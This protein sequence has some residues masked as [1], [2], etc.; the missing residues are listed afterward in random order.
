VP[1]CVDEVFGRSLSGGLAVSCFFCGA[2]FWGF[3]RE[4]CLFKFLV[5]WNTNQCVSVSFDGSHGLSPSEANM[6]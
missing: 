2:R 4:V 5:F 6:E 3:L 1:D